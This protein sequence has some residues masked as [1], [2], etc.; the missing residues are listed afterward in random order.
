MN[1]L[2]PLWLMVPVL[3][4]L[5]Q[6]FLKQSAATV[7]GTSY[8]WLDQLLTSPWFALAVVAEVA[9]F[10]IWMTVL[11][12]VDLSAAFPLSAV[13]YVLIMGI[14]WIAYGEPI[15]LTQLLGSV[16][17]LTGAWFVTGSGDAEPARHIRE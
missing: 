6:V 11:S 17:I 13:S 10:G 7:S 4:T 5:Q 1:A 14:A 9:C 15:G 3:N 8:H 2:R 12:E 16:L